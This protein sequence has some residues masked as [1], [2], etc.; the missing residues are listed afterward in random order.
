MLLA[1]ETITDHRDACSCSK[2]TIRRT[3]TRTDFG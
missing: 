1:I 2:S 3:E